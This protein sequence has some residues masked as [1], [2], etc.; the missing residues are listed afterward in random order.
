MTDLEI[1]KRRAV[2]LARPVADTTIAQD[3]SAIRV[4]IAGQLYAFPIAEV[5]RVV[6]AARV[7]PVPHAPPIVL[8]LIAD[9]GDVFPVFDARIW[10]GKP[11][12]PPADRHY[13]LLL[14]AGRDALALEVDAFHGSSSIDPQALSTRAGAASWLRGITLDGTLVVDVP[15]LLQ[16]PSF[17]QASGETPS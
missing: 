4:E 13:L 1:L 15:R 9:Q 2:Q 3:A 17:S 16:D 10:V 5:H 6:I 11:P 7:S 12:R 8:G 14:G